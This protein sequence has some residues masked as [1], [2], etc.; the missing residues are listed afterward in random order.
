VLK[1]LTI[2]KSNGTSTT[3]LDAINVY[4]EEKKQE[5]Q[6]KDKTLKIYITLNR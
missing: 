3:T 1:T 6:N 2:Y 4:I 5:A